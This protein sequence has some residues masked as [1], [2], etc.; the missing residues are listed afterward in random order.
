MHF[1]VKVIEIK[2][3]VK[4]MSNI[5][6]CDD[7]KEIVDAIEIYLKKRGLPDFQGL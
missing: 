2:R 5:L 6:V 4:E 1:N 7:D 3:G